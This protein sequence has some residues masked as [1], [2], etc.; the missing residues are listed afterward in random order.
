MIERVARRS[1]VSGA[2][3]EGAW[4]EQAKAASVTDRL[5]VRLQLRAYY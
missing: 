2:T 5:F 3:C 1:S 4:S